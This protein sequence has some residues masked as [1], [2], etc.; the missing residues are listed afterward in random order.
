MKQAHRRWHRGIWMVAAPLLLLLTLY[1]WLDLSSTP[2]SDQ[3]ISANDLP[4]LTTT[5]QPVDNRLP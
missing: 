3:P 5:D 1:S 4:D 2:T